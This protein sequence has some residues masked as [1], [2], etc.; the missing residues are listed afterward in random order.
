MKFSALMVLALT[1]VSLACG[2][3]S[4]HKSSMLP[5]AASANNVQP[6]VVNSRSCGE[7]REWLIYQCDRLRARD[8]ELSDD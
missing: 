4:S 2:G 6:I 3:G 8:F 7:L 5:V 1:A